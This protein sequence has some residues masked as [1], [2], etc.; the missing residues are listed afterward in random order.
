[1]F[2]SLNTKRQPIF[3]P[4]SELICL[5]VALV[6]IVQAT[7]R[8]IVRQ[9]RRRRGVAGRRGGAGS[10]ATWWCG[11]SASPPPHPAPT[12]YSSL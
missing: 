6:F 10:G 8:T 1:M 12:I 9:R 7:P 2:V 4:A 3:T 5:A 11:R